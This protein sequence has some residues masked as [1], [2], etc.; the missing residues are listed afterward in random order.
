MERNIAAEKKAAGDPCDDLRIENGRDNGRLTVRTEAGVSLIR[1]RS[2]AQF[3]PIRLIVKRSSAQ[4]RTADFDPD[5]YPEDR[6][7]LESIRSSGV[8]TPVMVKE[9]VPEDDDLL[10]DTCYELVY[11]HRRVSAC[12]VLGFSTVPAFVAE[13]AVDSKEITM[14]E[15]IGVR[16]LTAYERG[17]E[18]DA[19]LSTHDLSLRALS[20][21]NGMAP[22]YVSELIRAYRQ[23][24]ACPELSRIYQEGKVSSRYI[25]ELAALCGNADEK[26][27]QLLI[28]TLPELSQKQV[29]ELLA[30]CSDGASPA[31]V[32][33]DMGFSPDAGRADPER[34]A[35]T[36]GGTKDLWGRLESDSGFTAEI[37]ALYGC[38]EADVLEAV[39]ICRNGA[40]RPELLKGLLLLRRNGGTVSRP[41]LDC[42]MRITENEK[43]GRALFRYLD[44]CEKLAEKRLACRKRLEPLQDADPALRE[45][46]EKLVGD[47]FPDNN[48]DKS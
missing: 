2:P 37:A 44:S 1:R 16:T 20:E 27:Q 21:K 42:L 29:R 15:N 4:V 40:A 43:A 22:S 32:L 41:A 25:P 31:N 39:R 17:K 8:I 45:I 3:I 38:A 24:Q 9:Y 6:S 46:V 35:R 30:A 5:R 10:A 14:G 18:F 11:G 13:S 12:K 26:E 19:Y 23:V 7:L 36:S 47:P 28:E 48:A 33:K 34:P